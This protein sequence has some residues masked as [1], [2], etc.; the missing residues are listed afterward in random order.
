MIPQMRARS[1]LSSLY[2]SVRVERTVSSLA[3][4]M[5]NAAPSDRRVRLAKTCAAF[6]R[7][8]RGR[9]CRQETSAAANFACAT[10]AA[11]TRAPLSSS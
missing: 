4:T 8:S 10:A 1:A 3:T 7:V 9:S 2:A 5:A 6:F 11:A